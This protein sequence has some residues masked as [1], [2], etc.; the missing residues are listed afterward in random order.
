VIG[1]EYQMIDDSVNKDAL[2]G[3]K[4]QTGALYDMI[5][6]STHPAKPIGEFNH[7]R[8]LVRGDHVEHW[9]NDVKVV[10]A[11]LN[12]EEIKASVAKRWGPAPKLLA[13]LTKHARRQ[14]PISLQNH[15]AD[16]W[17]RNIKIRRLTQ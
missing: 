9:L 13:L 6:P 16:T 4:Y 1:F 7:S 17:F 8:L 2:R 15:G 3:G 14:A 5:A 12:A 11:D 10:D